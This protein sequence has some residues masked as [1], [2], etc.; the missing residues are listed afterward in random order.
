MEFLKKSHG[1]RSVTVPGM[2]K[3]EVWWY[4]QG[5]RCC[6]SLHFAVLAVWEMSSLMAQ[7]GCR[8]SRWLMTSIKEEGLSLTCM[9]CFISNETF[10][11]CPQADLPQ[12]PLDRAGPC[13]WSY[14]SPEGKWDPVGL[15]LTCFIN[16]GQGCLSRKSGRSPKEYQASV[17]ENSWRRCLKKENGP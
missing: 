16:W 4:F 7:G 17:V 8:H 2:L 6:L 14:Q 13:P 3:S 9:S 15:D 12:V 10:P 11:W 1:T 5:P